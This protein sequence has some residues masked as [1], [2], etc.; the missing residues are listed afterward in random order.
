MT[1]D[2][3][4]HMHIIK[5]ELLIVCINCELYEVLLQMYDCCDW[6]IRPVHVEDSRDSIT[7]D[8]SADC[9]IETFYLQV[10]VRREALYIN[11][12]ALENIYTWFII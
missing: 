10:Q 12:C 1:F 7:F 11:Q 4:Y 8:L 9:D 6:L 2:L 5:Q 3:K